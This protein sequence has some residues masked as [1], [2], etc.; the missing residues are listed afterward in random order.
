MFRCVLG[1]LYHAPCIFSSIIE[2][3]V[4]V[5]VHPIL[6]LRSSRSDKSGDLCNI[7]RDVFFFF[8]R[9][10]RFFI[11]N[12]RNDADELSLATLFRSRFLFKRKRLFRYTNLNF[13]HIFRSKNQRV[14]VSFSSHYHHH[15]SRIISN[16]HYIYIHFHKVNLKRGKRRIKERD[17][18]QLL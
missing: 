17:A 8:S 7:I 13:V 2:H 16:V 1:R 18:V 5:H 11:E 3:H 10:L 14:F 12:I 9:F 6:N 15:H 4:R